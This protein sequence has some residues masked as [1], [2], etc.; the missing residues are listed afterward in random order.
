MSMQTDVKGAHLTA[1]GVLVSHRSRLKGLMITCTG[2]A[3]SLIFRDGGATGAVKLTITTPAL[4][5]MENVVIPGQGV[6]FEEDIHVTLSDVDAV[7][8]FYG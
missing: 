5:N 4:A 7:T 2:T 3:G 8:A 1:T 6:L